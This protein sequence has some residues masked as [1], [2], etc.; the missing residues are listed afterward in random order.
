M[1]T[2]P[3]HS[4]SFDADRHAR[5][6]EQEQAAEAAGA[7]RDIADVPA[8]EVIASACIHLMS[9]AAVKLGL[10]EEENAEELTD[11]DEARKLINALAGLVTAAAPE[12]SDSH[13]RPIRDG[14]RSLQLR[15]REISTIPDAPGKGPGE[16][17]T[18]SVI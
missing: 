1:S 13:A 3:S 10:G 14:L 16:K 18:G 6:E 7:A 11:L 8:V 4:H 15:F 9:A 5:W 2:I 17:F 12:I